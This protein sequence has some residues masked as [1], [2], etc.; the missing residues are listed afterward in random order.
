MVVPG[1]L[2]DDLVV[3]LSILRLLL[4]GLGG[5]DNAELETSELLLLLVR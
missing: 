3:K 1:G 4:V 2:L 5:R